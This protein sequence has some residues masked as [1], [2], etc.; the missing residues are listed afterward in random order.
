MKKKILPI[1]IDD[2]KQMIE[3]Q[4]YYVDK[5]LFIKELLD[6]K[7]KVTLFTRPRRFGKTLNMSMLQYFFEINED[8]NDKLFDGL[9]ISRS[10]EGYLQ[11][12]GKY[13]VIS[14][15]LKSL[16]QPT[17]VL[18]YEQLKRVLKKEY[19]RHRDV[20]WNSGCLSDSDKTRYDKIM[21]LDGEKADYYIALEFLAQCLYQ[22]HGTKVIILIDGYDVPLE[23][24]YF[25]GYYEEMVS[26]IRSL[27]ESALKSNKNL[28]FAVITGC[29]RISKESI[30]T[31]LN[32]LEI[33]SILNE[34]YSEHFGFT[35][36][37]LDEMLT[38]YDIMEKQQ[39]MEEWYDG[40][41]F[42]GTD[43]YNPW[44]VI[45]FVK[46]CVRNNN[47]L[48]EPY[49]SNTSSNSI[50][51]KLVERATL[52]VK[53]EIE[54]LIEGKTIEKPVHEDITY[55]D[56]DS[57]QD[58]LWN[59]LFFTGYLKKSNERMKAE[60]KYIELSIPNSEVRYIYKT[61]VLRWFEEQVK[62]KDLTTL[63]HSIIDGKV[64]E[65]EKELS[66]RLRESISFYDNKEAF[67][68]GFLLG[69]LGGMDEYL[70][71]SNREAGDD[72]YDICLRSL[73]VAK[74]VIL[75]EVKLASKYPEMQ[76]KSEEAMEQIDT[77]NYKEAILGEGY[78]ELINYG[79]SFYKKNCKVMMKR[80]RL[81]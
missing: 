51:R 39:L 71:D 43:V 26:L 30:F 78:Q 33:I 40:F 2:F 55:E 66:D 5:T 12:M 49:W 23:N 16:K 75:I 17:F 14:L 10:G 37:E 41:R 8:E 73:D 50:V 1:G 61:T 72:R 42:G 25:E 52:S 48:P 11:H 58:N 57:T 27:F 76:A 69:L 13:P 53:Q 19:D 68:H 31:G 35:Q 65:L 63:Y 59:F 21:C 4:Y 46:A 74:P 77:R 18:A 28:E 67:Y 38:Y 56:I 64:L 47:V 32:N 36:R 6:M 60:T 3:G 70:I 15:T 34:Y 44:S 81:S 79:I 24:A 80:E 29:L 45:N 62:Q 54:L 22:C 9:K 20:I 7:G